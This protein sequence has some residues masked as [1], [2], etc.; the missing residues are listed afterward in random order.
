M[1]FFV[2][3][4]CNETLKKHQ[5]DKHAL[6]CRQCQAVTCV[7]CSVTFYGNDYAAHISCISEAEKYEGSLFKA[8]KVKLNPQEAWNLVVESAA[9]DR[10]NEAPVAI[11]SFLP[12]LQKLGN[13]PRQQKKFVNFVKNS[14]RL[15]NE[16]LINQM[17][18]FLEKLN[19]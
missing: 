5:V 12:S 18:S 10:V 8:K 3:E 11:K 2:C 16:S 13:V 14:L 1:V 7:D 4:G 15:H 6:R 9:S 17:W 19:D